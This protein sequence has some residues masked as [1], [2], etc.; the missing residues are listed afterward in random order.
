[1]LANDSCA[2]VRLAAVA[3]KCGLSVSHFARSFKVS[4]GQS[5]H[6]WVIGLRIERAKHFLLCSDEPLIEIAHKTGFC[7]Q[8]SFNRTFTKV[9]GNSPGRWRRDFKA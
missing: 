1:M 2:D 5:T 7:D 9:M 8:A 6:R 3:K 4:F